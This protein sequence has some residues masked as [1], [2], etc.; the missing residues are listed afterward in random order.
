[1][2]ARFT[3]FCILLSHL[4]ATLLPSFAA[5]IP[6]KAGHWHGFE[7]RDFLHEGLKCIVVLPKSE[8]KGRPWVWR[9]RFFGH[10]PQ[11]DIALLKLG[12]HVCYCEVGGLFGNTEAVQRWNRFHALLTKKHG[13]S[14]KPALE[15]MSRGGLIIYNWAA[16]NPGKVACIYGDA[17]VCDIRSWPGGKGKGKGGGGAWKGALKAHGITEEESVEASVSPVHKLGPIAKAKIPLLHVVGAAD[18]V[19][20]VE[21]NSAVI[22][23][24]YRKLG[25]EIKVISK[26]GVGHHP[27]ALKD[28]GP[29][30]DFIRKH[31]TGL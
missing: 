28:P 14:G 29:I 20:P 16:A 23:E 22:V 21:E 7:R 24:R 4:I 17:P 8:A 10:Q 6:G 19:V 13:F 25:G 9:A 30:I 11:A 27:H 3:F 15:G 12:F 26:P 2:K 5:E 31:T 1:M 18:T